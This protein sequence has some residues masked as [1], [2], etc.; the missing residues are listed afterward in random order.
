MKMIWLFLALVTFLVVWV[1][2]TV[3]LGLAVR[4][5]FPGFSGDIP[6]LGV[7]WASLP[8]SALGVLAG[9]RVFRTLVGERQ[10]GTTK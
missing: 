7:N 4:S 10:R 2:V 1:V 6:V 9:Q 3:L 5:M 8:G